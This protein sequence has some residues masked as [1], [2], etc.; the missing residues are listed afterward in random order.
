MQRQGIKVLI[1]DDEDRFRSTLKKLLSVQGFEVFEAEDGLKALEKVKEEKFD[2]IL[3]DVKMP[4]MHGIEA[5]TQIKKLDPLPEII[6]LTGH[7]SVDVAV[8]M[9][10]FGA[11]EY[12]LKPCPTEELIAK[13]EEAYEKKRAKEAL[14]SK[15]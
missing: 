7:A 14:K 10:K 3:L 4:G 13:I 15:L 8:Q 12:L 9:I 2:I 1:V 5:L 11:Y 6:V